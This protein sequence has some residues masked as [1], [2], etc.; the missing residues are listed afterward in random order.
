MRL[1]TLQSIRRDKDM[2]KTRAMIWVMATGLLAAP[3]SAETLNQALA[4]ALG[5]N[6]SLA[7]AKSTY[8]SIYK[9][10]FV[11][12][13]DMLPQVT[14]FAR[15]SRSNTDA[16]TYR[17]GNVFAAGNVGD[18][19]RDSYGIRV[20]QDLFTSGKNINA[21]RSK[22]AEA[23]SQRAVLTNTEQQILLSA[24]SAYLSVLENRSILKLNEQNV[25]ILQRQLDANLD[26]FEVGVVTRTDIA[27]SQAALAGAQSALLSSQANL[28]GSNAVYREV[29]GLDPAGLEPVSERPRLPST[30]E[31]AIDIARR[32]N[33]SLIASKEMSASGRYNAYSALGAALP[34]I[35]VTG[36]YTVTE[37]PSV[38]LAGIE[39]EVTDVVVQLNVPIFRG[40][41]SISGISA[42]SDYADSLKYQVHASSDGMERGVIVAWNNYQAAQSVIPARQQQIEA[43]E[44]ALDGVIQENALGTRTTLDVLNAEQGLLD[45]RVAMIT[46][47]TDRNVA[48]FN[49]LASI[50]RL[51][52][53]RLRIEPVKL[54]EAE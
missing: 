27:Q 23:R 52:G 15:E 32:E 19:D 18:H 42:A 49:V 35:S 26:R 2:M 3:A 40:G 5:R 31:K 6:P 16:T 45:A 22:R 46:A 11:T 7:A 53:E 4:E 14:A 12:M 48:A 8:E 24:A 30:L 43:S 50:G 34:S 47:D 10:Q 37:D 25:V 36:S 13:A 17:D 20:T 39:T 51:T 54:S 1:V 21:F 29:I 28:R 9:S 38:A 41:R 44:I 33:P